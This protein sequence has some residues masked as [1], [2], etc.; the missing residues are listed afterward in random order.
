MTTVYVVQI[1]DDY[2]D[3][4]VV[5]YAG[6]DKFDAEEAVNKYQ[7]GDGVIRWSEWVDGFNTVWKRGKSIIE[8]EETE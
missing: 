4:G 7:R 6:I 5:V 2:Q 1:G 8:W 3:A